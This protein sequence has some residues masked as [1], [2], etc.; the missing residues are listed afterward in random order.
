MIKHDAV[1]PE[2]LG[3]PEPAALG[4]VGRQR[5]RPQRSA[6]VTGL[7][8][9]SDSYRERQHEDGVARAL[10]RASGKDARRGRASGTSMV[11]KNG[12]PLLVELIAMK[13]HVKELD[14]Q[15]KDVQGTLDQ[16]LAALERSAMGGVP[17]V[18]EDL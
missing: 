16:V 5:S 18:W 4:S 12:D 15:M 9:R 7:G 10:G 3:V 14:H 8:F 11:E 1:V 6:T 2:D 13:Q 17:G